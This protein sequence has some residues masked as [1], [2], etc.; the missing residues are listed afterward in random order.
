VGSLSIRLASLWLERVMKV[1]GGASIRVKDLAVR[2]EIR[3]LQMEAWTPR[4][5]GETEGGRHADHGQY[6][7][8]DGEL[9]M[10]ITPEPSVGLG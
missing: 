6:V 7:I 2:Y 4:R 5:R 8:Q 3:R 9:Q 1:G 10:Q